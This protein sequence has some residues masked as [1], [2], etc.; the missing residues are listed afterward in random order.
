MV[1]EV[2]IEGEVVGE[3]GW[4]HLRHDLVSREDKHFLA[5]L[6]VLGPGDRFRLRYRLHPSGPLSG[7]ICRG[8]AD[9]LD[10]DRL[11]LRLDVA[12]L[13]ILPEEGE[14]LGV[15]VEV[16]EESVERRVEPQPLH[17]RSGPN[18]LGLAPCATLDEKNR[19]VAEACPAGQVIVGPRF[20]A[21]LGT[22]LEVVHRLEGVAGSSRL[23][24]AVGSQGPPMV[25]AQSPIETLEEGE[26]L[27]IV[28]SFEVTAV[29]NQ[30]VVGLALEEG[31]PEDSSFRVLDTSV[32]M[33]LP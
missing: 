9:L 22:Q 17:L 15:G 4:L 10:T 18:G 27:D 25:L 21:P 23:F 8:S 19:V 29:L 12:E 11:D 16:L 28:L 24:S 2:E 20:Y 31:L 1:V 33:M 5:R 3:Q 26:T 7:L 6:P 32:T 14:A 30:I 13:R